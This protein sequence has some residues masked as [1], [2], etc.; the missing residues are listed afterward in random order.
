MVSS[1]YSTLHD[2]HKLFEGKETFL[3]DATPYET[4]L[5]KISEK[6]KTTHA[7]LFGEKLLHQHSGV[8]M[9]HLV[10]SRSWITA[11]AAEGPL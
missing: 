9:N 10:R 5:G 6:T 2:L 11:C 3:Q 4:I 8:P 1:Q 7:P